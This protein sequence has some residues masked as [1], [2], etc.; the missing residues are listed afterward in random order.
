MILETRIL[1]FNL[2]DIYKKTR[3]LLSLILEFTLKYYN[4]KLYYV[5]SKFNGIVNFF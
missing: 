3:L 2:L 1:L 4:T 5:C